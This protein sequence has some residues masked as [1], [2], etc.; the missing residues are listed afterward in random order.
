MEAL[1][2]AGTDVR[3][4]AVD[5]EDQDGWPRGRR[6]GN[7]TYGNAYDSSIEVQRAKATTL[8]CRG[9]IVKITV[10]DLQRQRDN[11]LQ[12][13]LDGFRLRD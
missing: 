10:R 2:R 13:W 1:C 4:Y 9:A 12:A 5:D 11:G 7:D 3:V 6:H 8:M